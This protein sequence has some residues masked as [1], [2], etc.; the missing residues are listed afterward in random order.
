MPNPYAFN[1]RGDVKKVMT[2]NA[3][4]VGYFH[5][6]QN[7]I[8]LTRE[9]KNHLF[10]LLQSNSGD[11]YYRLMGVAIPF[12]AYLKKYWVQY[13]YGNIVQIYAPDKTSIRKSFYTCQGIIKIVEI[14]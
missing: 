13:E 12:W 7:D 3:S 6:L 5:M 10:H 2:S 11:R 8:K 1:D 4:A 14:L 9:E